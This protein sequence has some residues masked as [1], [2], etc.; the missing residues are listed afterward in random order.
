MNIGV[1]IDDTIVINSSYFLNHILEEDLPKY[2]LI[3]IRN[4]MPDIMAGKIPEFLMPYLAPIYKK[5]NLLYEVYP[6]AVPVLTRLKRKNRI[7]IAT[8][9]CNAML[10]GCEDTTTA[11]LEMKGIPYDELYYG[12]SDKKTFCLEHNIDLFID[13]SIRHITDIS[14]SG[15]STILFESEINKNCK[16]RSLRS[17][18]W[19]DVEQKINRINN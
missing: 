18:D 4:N 5:Y 16:T 11:Y 7:I 12:V 9:R 14:S 8:G 2:I 15:I 19:L 6:N 13:D 3:E 1:D 17:N 10:D